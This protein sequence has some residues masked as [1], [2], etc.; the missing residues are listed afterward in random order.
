MAEGLTGYDTAQ[1]DPASGEAIWLFTGERRGQPFSI[2]KTAPQLVTML[3]IKT[4]TAKRMSAELRELRVRGRPQSEIDAK[5]LE[6]DTE[7]A[8]QRM[9]RFAL[10]VI[11]DNA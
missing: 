3:R 7:Q 11:Y 4:A 10:D 1:T 8:D 9:V 2:E 6:R 5:L